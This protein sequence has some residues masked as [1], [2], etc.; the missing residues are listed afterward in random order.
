MLI[1]KNKYHIYK[2]EETKRT[3]KAL[4]DKRNALIAAGRYT[5]AIDDILV[6]ILS[7]KPKRVFSVGFWLLR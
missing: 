3:V 1:K 7:R 6:R 4:I 2:I 5:D